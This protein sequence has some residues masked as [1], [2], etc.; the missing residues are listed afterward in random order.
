MQAM[1]TL[2]LAA[3]MPCGSR[4]NA[5]MPTQP[6]NTYERELLAAAKTPENRAMIEEFLRE[7]PQ[8]DPASDSD[9]EPELEATFFQP[10]KPPVR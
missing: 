4:H 9:S 2:L 1:A 10:K 7:C 8:V 5:P 3:C 6:K